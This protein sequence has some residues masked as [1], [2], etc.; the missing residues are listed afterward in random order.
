[1]RQ[2]PLTFERRRVCRQHFQQFVDVIHEV[3]AGP[4]LEVGQERHHA[5]SLGQPSVLLDDLGRGVDRQ[6]PGA[7]GIQEVPDQTGVE[8]HDRHGIVDIG[9]DVGDPEFQRREPD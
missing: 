8:R 1:M 9:A 6:G 3:N 5:V 4:G 2:F 7:H